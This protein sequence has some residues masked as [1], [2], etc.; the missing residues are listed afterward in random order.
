MLP[1]VARR[2]LLVEGGGGGEG[3]VVG[4]GEG[5]RGGGTGDLTWKKRAKSAFVGFGPSSC[6]GG[7][8]IVWNSLGKTKALSEFVPFKSQK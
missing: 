4:G 5:V 2:E 6:F 3:G 8:I 7:L 1:S